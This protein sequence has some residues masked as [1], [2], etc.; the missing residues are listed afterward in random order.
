MGYRDKQKQKEYQRLYKKKHL[1]QVRLGEI[2]ARGYDRLIVITDEQ[3]ATPSGAPLNDAKGYFINVASYK[4]GIGYG[5]WNHIDGW[6]ESIIDYIQ[7]YEGLD[8]S[9]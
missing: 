7:E 6:S 1:V 3:S 4:N 8:V 2:K 5:P 9:N